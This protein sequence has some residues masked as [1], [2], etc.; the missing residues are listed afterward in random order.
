MDI[1][2]VVSITMYNFNTMVITLYTSITYRIHY[3][4]YF[5]TVITSCISI[6][7]IILKTSIRSNIKHLLYYW[8]FLNVFNTKG[9]KNIAI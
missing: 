4:L 2:Y 6:V 5:Y 7:L 8:I 3:V 9:G 1:L